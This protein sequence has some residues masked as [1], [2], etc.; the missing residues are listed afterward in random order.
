LSSS[1][2][3]PTS[4]PTVLS[5]STS[6]TV[7]SKLTVRSVAV[8][9]GSHQAVEDVGHGRT[10]REESVGTRLRLGE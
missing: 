1:T 2:W 7:A 4:A 6:D 10:L 9:D 8:G 3:N 5:C